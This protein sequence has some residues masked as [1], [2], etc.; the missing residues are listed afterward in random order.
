[1][2]ACEHL[3]I[4]DPVPL[5]SAELQVV[6]WIGTVG[7]RPRCRCLLVADSLLSL[8]RMSRRNR[9]FDQRLD[10]RQ[11][12]PYVGALP[13]MFRGREDLCGSCCLVRD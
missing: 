9:W 1:M 11:A 4:P 5:S 7:R 10:P 13:L 8:S 3:N 6:Q 2:S 12:G